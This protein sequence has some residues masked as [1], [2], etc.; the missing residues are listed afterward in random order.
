MASQSAK[1]RDYR[2]G[3]KKAHVE[4]GL[5]ALSLAIFSCIGHGHISNCGQVQRGKRGLTMRKPN[6]TFR[7][8]LAGAKGSAD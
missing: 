2:T 1:D 6:L 7:F 5:A 4:R 8:R 3:W